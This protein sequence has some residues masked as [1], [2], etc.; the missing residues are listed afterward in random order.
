MFFFV[1]QAFEIIFTYSTLQLSLEILDLHLG[2]IKFTVRKID[3][4][5]ILNLILKFLII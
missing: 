5:I 1:C 4:H 3:S 2:F